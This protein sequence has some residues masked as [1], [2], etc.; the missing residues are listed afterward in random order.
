LI[1]GIS[2]PPQG[3]KD[4]FFPTQFSQSFST[5]CMACLWKQNLSYWR[6][7]PYTVVRFFFSLIVALMFGTIFW[8]LGSKR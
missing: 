8:R 4:L 6:N 3:S 1:K 2:R 5:Q 7:P